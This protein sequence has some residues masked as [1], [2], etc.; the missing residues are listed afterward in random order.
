MEKRIEMTLWWINHVLQCEYIPKM[1]ATP[2]MLEC[3]ITEATL[4]FFRAFK[5]EPTTLITRLTE[6]LWVLFISLTD[7]SSRLLSSCD[8]EI[9]PSVLCRIFQ[10]LNYTLR[11]PGA[12]REEPSAVA[13]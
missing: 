12:R 1:Y 2:N 6:R 5:I 8:P 3:H 7:A 11:R 13:Y 4:T 10:F 9:V